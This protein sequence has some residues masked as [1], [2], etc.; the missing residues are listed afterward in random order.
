MQPPVSSTSDETQSIRWA[1]VLPLFHIVLYIILLVVSRMGRG[2][3]PEGVSIEILDPLP[4]RVAFSLNA[5]A[6]WSA[7]LVAA[8]SADSGRSRSRFRT[9]GDHRSEVM[10]ITIPA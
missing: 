5:P 3:A 6:F 4:E 2:E 8:I 1:I 10:S 7:M 9:D